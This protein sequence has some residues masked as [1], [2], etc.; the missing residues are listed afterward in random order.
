MLF[1]YISAKM[2][3]TVMTQKHKKKLNANRK[4]LVDNILIDNISNDLLQNQ[5]LTNRDLQHIKAEVG[6]GKNEKLLDILEK[7]SDDKYFKF[8]QVLNANGHEHLAELLVPNNSNSC[9]TTAAATGPYLTSI[10]L[11]LENVV[12]M[13]INYCLSSVKQILLIKVIKLF[14]EQSCP[15]TDFACLY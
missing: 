5:I 10:I 6:S 7:K 1:I 8:V 15:V 12:F 11:F 13:C 3:V 4:N 9:R 14:Q 2:S